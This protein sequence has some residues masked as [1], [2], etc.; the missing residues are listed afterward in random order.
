MK[1]LTGYRILIVED[2]SDLCGLIADDFR[3]AGGDVDTAGSGR[4]A[5]SMAFE[6]EYDF[7]LSDVRMPN[8]D[9]IF[10][11]EGIMNLKNQKPLFFLYSGYNDISKEVA[12]KFGVLKIFSKPVSCKIMIDSIKEFLQKES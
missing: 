2:D 8:G 12:E 6:N 1:K 3:M 9:G 10:L 11:A 5:L 4:D 7:I